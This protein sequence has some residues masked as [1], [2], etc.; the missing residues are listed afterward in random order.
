M[1]KYYRITF[2]NSLGCFIVRIVFK[3]R[4]YLL[5]ACD[6]GLWGDMCINICSCLSTDTP[7]DV[8]TGCEECSDGWTGKY[9]CH[10]GHP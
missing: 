10:H 5:L 6:V 9:T 4:C 8:T 3:V 1:F 2:L 7:C